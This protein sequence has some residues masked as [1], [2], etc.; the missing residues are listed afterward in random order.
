MATTNWIADA[1]HSEIGFRIKHLMI[2]NVKGKFSDFEV[3]AQTEGEDFS[4]AKISFSADVASIHTGN[5]DRDNH[6]RSADF[7]DAENHPKMTFEAT[8]VG[9]ADGDGNFKLS[10]NLSIRGTSR[11]VTLDVEMGGVAKDPWGNTKAGFTISGKINRKDWGLTWNAPTEAGG[12][13]VSE[14]VKL[15]ID[16]QLLKQG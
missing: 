7:F 1:S 13:L 2:T 5:N 14:E 3:S 9:K 4:T 6:L 10:G 15:N 11:P 12:L 16:L 8:E